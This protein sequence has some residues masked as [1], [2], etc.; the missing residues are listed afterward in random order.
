MQTSPPHLGEGTLARFA[1]QGGGAVGVGLSGG[2][3]PSMQ[4]SPPHLGEGTLARFA[5][6]GGG[7]VG[8]EPWLAL[9]AKGEGLK[10]FFGH[11][12]CKLQVVL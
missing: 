12:V 4:T 3:E 11:F 9:R 8:V 1:S 2:A 5:S 6:Q 10:K 7:A